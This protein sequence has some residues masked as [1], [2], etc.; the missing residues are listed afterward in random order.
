M[1]ILPQEGRLYIQAEFGK[2]MVSPG[3]SWDLGGGPLDFTY[4]L[5]EPVLELLFH[6]PPNGPGACQQPVD[7]LHRQ[8]VVK[9]AWAYLEC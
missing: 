6:P 3:S 1:P 8:R 9:V 4:V 5:F 2:L 7:A